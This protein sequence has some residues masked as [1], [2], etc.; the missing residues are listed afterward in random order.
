MA[1]AIPTPA[2][3]HIPA[4]RFASQSFIGELERQL[5]ETLSDIAIFCINIK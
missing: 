1:Y 5:S 3:T 4:H 2:L